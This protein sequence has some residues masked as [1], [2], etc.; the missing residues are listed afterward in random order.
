MTVIFADG[1]DWYAQADILKR[2][3]A[4]VTPAGTTGS[5]VNGTV[6]PLAARSPGGQGYLGL[7]QS[8][9]SY[10][11]SIVKTFGTNYT[12]GLLGF[13][14]NANALG[15]ISK[16]L[17]VIYDGT[18]E[19]ISVRTNASSVLTVTRNGTVL[20]TGTTVIASTGWMFIEI[21][22]TIHPSAGIVE[23]KLNGAAE[24]ASTTSLNTRNSAN[25]QWNGVGIGGSTQG[26]FHDDVYVLDTSTGSNTTFLG[27]VRICP[28]IP[29]AAG[30]TTAWTANGGTNV[31]NVSEMFEDGDTSF[32]Q[33]ST[34]SQI[35]TFVLGDLPA[36]SGSV[37]A[38]QV[39]TVA[40]QDAGAARTIAP[41]LRI[42]GTDYAGTAVALSTSYQA[43]AQVYDVSPATSTA[44][45]ISEVN[46]AEAGYKLVS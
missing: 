25:T 45:T 17:A 26:H 18:T 1:F 42:S 8:A 24:I 35:D 44:W 6:S 43:L 9:T 23:L 31:G 10:T 3:T 41:V 11:T 4:V 33:S 7:N 36:A 32:N 20:A 40:R 27:P 39:I 21:K 12:Q 30:A 22:Y 46:G 13:A 28:V 37:L 29:V 15:T 38:A 16:T 34:A 2:W 14:F 19:Q 5:Y